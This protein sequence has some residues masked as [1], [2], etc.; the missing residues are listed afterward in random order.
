MVWWTSAEF[1][2][3]ETNVNGVA[4]R[5]LDPDFEKISVLSAD[6]I[7]KA[8]PGSDKDIKANK[9]SF[10]YDVKRDHL[11]RAIV[12]V[13]SGKRSKGRFLAVLEKHGENWEKIFLTKIP[14]KPGFSCM[15]S[16]S[17]TAITWCSCMEC[18]VCNDVTWDKKKGYEFIPDKDE[19]NP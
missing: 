3:K 10:T 5:K 2:P 12:G 6:S 8:Y 7:L 15:L 17:P 9:A 11:Q 4:A 13:Y 19:A 18:D 16:P 14:G 1:E